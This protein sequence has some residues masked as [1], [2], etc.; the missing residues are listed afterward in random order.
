[1]NKIAYKIVLSFLVTVTFLVSCAQPNTPPV[2]YTV[3]FDSQEASTAANPATITLT[4][5]VLTTGTFPT[6]PIKTGYTFGGWWTKALGQGTQ[7]TTVTTVSKNIT[8]YAKWTVIT[9]DVIFDS[10]GGSAVV[11][12]N[13]TFGSL[14]TKPSDPTRTG[15]TFGGWYKEAPC[16]TAWNFASDT[17]L[18]ATTLYAKWIVN[19][20]AVTFD[21]QGGSA[22]D[23][24]NPAF[25]SLITKPTD[26]TKTGYF[27]GG[28]YK[29]APCLTAWNF[30]S[31][32]LLNTTTLY[33]KWTVKTYEVTF[34]TQVGVIVKGVNLAFGSLI[35]K[36]AD[37]TKTGFT[38]EGW[39]KEATCLTAWN[40]TTDTVLTRTI[41]YARWTLK[42]Y[43]VTYDSQGA[44][45]EA[46]PTSSIVTFPSVN[47]TTFTTPPTKN[48]WALE[49]WWTEPNG[50]GT[51]FTTSTTV[52][53]DLT[54]YAH[55]V[56]STPGLSFSKVSSGYSVT[57]GTANTN[58]AVIIP[59]YWNGENVS[60]IGWDA[61]KN[62][63][64][65]TN[66]TI[67]SG[68]TSIGNDAFLGCTG[69]SSITIPAG[70]TSINSYVFKG[71]SGL[72]NLTIPAGVTSI[73]DYAFHG[74]S[75]LT[76]LTIPAG[77]TSIQG[78]AFYGCSGLT[79]LTIP[80]GVTYIGSFAFYNC[81][82]LTGLTIPS[83][84]T[85]ISQ[86]AFYNC[87]G[88]TNLTMP[89]E[90]TA[91]GDAAF[92]G[93]SGLTSLTLPAGVTSIGEGAFSGCSGL[94]SLTIPVGVTSISA[95]TFNSCIGLTS[96]SIPSGVISIGNFAFKNCTGLTSLTLPA[97]VTSIGE[98]TFYNCSG[99][100]NLTLP[101]GVTSI[102]NIAF[103]KCTGL[104]SLSIPSGVTSIGNFS[105]QE[106]ANLTNLTI[107]AGVVYIGMEAFIYCSGLTFVLVNPTTP[108]T[109]GSGMFRNTSTSIKVPAGS[110]DAYKT[111]PGWSEH[112]SRIVSQ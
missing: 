2:V 6:D 108:P 70:V 16:L 28:W 61:F 14:I 17:L 103:Y 71:C 83:G 20:Y 4:A 32:T 12:I 13:P 82:G 5:P 75:G 96:L 21:S 11:G 105:F 45:V 42:K 27:F 68:V 23:G 25:G 79:S 7:F 29:E 66:L 47:L 58:G 89:N 37:P 38:F 100:T 34:D 51:K 41:L 92:F 64:G 104:T 30:T 99:I 91:I 74:C 40:F 63:T 85:S 24:I 94:T 95:G 88:L 106:C 33:A 35:T 90:V 84:V 10:Q 22:V 111:D 56:I 57:K 52:S 3:T 102:G 44:E 53:T 15:Y 93:C 8:L 109:N 54:L 101:P 31:D 36:P 81:T 65:L 69:L 78:Y 18:A 98:E 62:C 110:V 86:Y 50:E 73:G 43:V 48:G 87:S 46:N 72:T 9:L 67:P 77:V 49:G 59:D 39:Y 112:A 107:P 80:A 1:M 19:N 26:P 60:A 76:S 55:W 97:G